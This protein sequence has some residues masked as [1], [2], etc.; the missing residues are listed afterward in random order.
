GTT[1]C[2]RVA[3]GDARRKSTQP[4]PDAARVEPAPRKAE[5]PG[6]GAVFGSAGA[7]R[8]ALRHAITLQP[9]AA[10]GGRGAAQDDQVRTQEPERRRAI[11][12]RRRR[13]PR[14]PFDFLA[15]CETPS[16]SN[17]MHS[18][19]PTTKPQP[20]G[21]VIG[22]VAVTLLLASLGQT[23]VS[24]ALPVIVAELGGLEHLTWVVTA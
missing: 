1:Q 10:T 4:R 2:R 8:A 20:V 11:A 6:Q 17:S 23:I 19:P 22:A 9:A 5:R 24:T 13:P 3:A 18:E 7:L 14:L 15:S 12:A 21:L 16:E